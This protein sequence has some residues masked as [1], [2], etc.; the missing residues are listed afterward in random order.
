LFNIGCVAITQGKF[1]STPRE[2]IDTVWDIYQRQGVN[3]LAGMKHTMKEYETQGATHVVSQSAPSS[4]SEPNR[5]T[6]LTLSTTVV[7]KSVLLDISTL[8]R[9]AF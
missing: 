7:K 3:I 9:L 4:E 8:E 6:S 5:S 2:I 1:S